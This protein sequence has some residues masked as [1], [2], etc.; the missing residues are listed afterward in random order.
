[1]HVCL[2]ARKKSDTERERE[3]HKDHWNKYCDNNSNNSIHVAYGEAMIVKET[4]GEIDFAT[5]TCSAVMS[6]EWLRHKQSDDRTND[7]NR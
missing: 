7:V 3:L 6:D 5:R 4:S 2:E 1:M